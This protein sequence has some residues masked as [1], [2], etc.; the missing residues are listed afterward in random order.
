MADPVFLFCVE[1]IEY[2]YASPV[3]VLPEVVI[4]AIGKIQKV[5]R[6]DS[7]GNIVPVH[8]LKVS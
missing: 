1:L 6:Y 5:P 2:R 4:G 8:T 3:L 7:K